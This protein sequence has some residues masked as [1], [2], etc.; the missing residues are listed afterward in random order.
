[1]TDIHSPVHSYVVGALTAAEAHEFERHLIECAECVSEVI[2]NRAVTSALSTAV[3]TEP[4]LSLRAK[5]LA[6]ITTVPQLDAVASLPSQPVSTRRSHPLTESASV[7]H[8]ER[9]SADPTG[10]VVPLRRQRWTTSL[11]AA[12][13]MIAAVGFGGWAL[14][15]RQDAAQSQ[16]AAQAAVAQ[17]QQLTRVVSADDVRT[18]S[19]RFVTTEHTG[20]VVMSAKRDAA[21][22]VAS[23]L[24][25]LPDGKVY[26][27]WTI[28]GDPEPAGT[29]TP[30]GTESLVQLPSSA[31]DAKSIAITVE[32]K[33][34]SAHPTSDA[35]F[36]VS[37]P[38]RD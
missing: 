1:M 12:A 14:Q 28:N 29:F 37:L 20:T 7:V 18:V 15:A 2:D 36:T 11:L 25:Q 34:G 3:A 30:Q 21:L 33:G 4:P 31:F 13:A 35:I 10:T 5:V 27:A 22:F 6:K 19:S 24:D 26:E 38:E 8:T 32:P 9:R 23:D 16:E 17:R